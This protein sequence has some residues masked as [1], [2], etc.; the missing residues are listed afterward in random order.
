MT[1]ESAQSPAA[2]A[3]PRCGSPLVRST[4]KV[5]PRAGQPLWRCSDFGCPTLINIDEGDET[6]IAPVAG[7]SAQAR[8]ERERLAST[9]RVR[10]F[11]PFL[12]A[13]GVLLAAVAFFAG[14][15]IVADLR[16]AAFGPFVVALLF[17]WLVVRLPAEVIY[18]GKGAEG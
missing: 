1:A 5:G 9:E 16:L 14:L 3:C 4:A 10:R 17:L 12:A 2:L 13:S 15:A 6:P 11:A 8:F 18:W 7:E